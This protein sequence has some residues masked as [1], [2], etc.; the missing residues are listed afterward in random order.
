MASFER[1]EQIKTFLEKTPE[2]AFLN[3][4]LAIEYIALNKDDEAKSIFVKLIEVQPD[5]FATY[6]HL[7]KLYERE[8]NDSKAIATYEAGINV[9]KRL[10][11]KHALSELSA[12]LEEL[13]F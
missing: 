3:Y 9:T 12:A 5:Y 1:I 13:T 4:A 2:D 11:E 8:A 6:Y 7:A 10:G